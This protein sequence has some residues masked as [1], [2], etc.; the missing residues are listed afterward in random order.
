MDKKTA[1]EESERLRK[2][3]YRDAALGM[4]SPTDR[5]IMQQY[6][7]LTTGV[8]ALFNKASNRRLEE[9]FRLADEA[10]F[11]ATGSTAALRVSRDE[12]LKQADI[13]FMRMKGLS[14]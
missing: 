7:G 5:V 9:S 13:R 11:E 8:A 14:L 6:P 1:L 4:A 10:E 12:E 2:R 3:A